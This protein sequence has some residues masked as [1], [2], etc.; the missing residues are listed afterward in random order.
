MQKQKHIPR[1]IG[2]AWSEGLLSH[3]YPDYAPQTHDMPLDAILSA[4]GWIPRQPAID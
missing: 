1:T 4:E 2:I 3:K